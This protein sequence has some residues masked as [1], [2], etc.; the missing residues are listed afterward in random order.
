MR[1]GGIVGPGS[2]QDKE[3]VLPG[4]PLD[5]P[6]ADTSTVETLSVEPEPVVISLF[7][8]VHKRSPC[9]PLLLPSHATLPPQQRGRDGEDAVAD[10]EEDDD[11]EELAF[12]C[13]DP[14]AFTISADEIFSNG[15]IRPIYPIFNR[16]LIVEH[17]DC[18]KGKNLSPSIHLPLRKILIN[19]LDASPVSSSPSTFSSPESDS[20][21]RIPNRK[22]C[23]WSSKSAPPETPDR[24]KKSNSTGSS[25]WW[26]FRDLLH[27]SSND[28][29]DSFVF[30]STSAIKR[31]EKEKTQKSI[32]SF[33]TSTSA[34]AKGKAVSAHEMHYMRN[35]KMSEGDRHRSNLPYRQDLALMCTR[36]K[37]KREVMG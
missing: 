5:R 6:I 23:L 12:V 1:I 4:S 19:G 26:R 18:D 22:Y 21:N 3:R 2:F 24:C 8:T 31:G 28:G 20:L 29:K 14:N 16:D 32:S 11:D 9:S 35:R 30:L 25:K 7:I 36:I 17:G 15:Q 34:S 10:T 13:Q 33:S 27:R 37:N